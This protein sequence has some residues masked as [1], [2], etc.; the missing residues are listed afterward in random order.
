MSALLT[1]TF[2]RT[3]QRLKTLPFLYLFSTAIAWGMPQGGTPTVQ[4]GTG[5]FV[6]VHQ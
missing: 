6:V 1:G 5:Q 4:T 2:K 3:Q